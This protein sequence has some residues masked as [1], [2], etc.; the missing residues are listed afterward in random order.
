M[1]IFSLRERELY[2]KKDCKIRQRNLSLTALLY[3]YIAIFLFLFGWVKLVIAVPAGIALGYGL[4]HFARDIHSDNSTLQ[5]TPTMLF[6]TLAASLVI[7]VL[8]GAGGFLGQHDDWIKHNYLLHDLVTR[9]WPVYYEADGSP[10]MLTYYLGQ[11]LLPA[12]CG[13]LVHSFRMA[14][15]AQ[16]VYYAVGLFLIY[17]LLFPMV[18]ANTSRK[19]MSVLFIVPAFACC[20]LI[21]EALVFLLYAPVTSFPTNSCHLY[22]GPFSLPIRS[23]YGALS[24]IAV[25]TLPAWL[26][27]LLFAKSPKEISHYGLIV[28]PLLLSSTFAFIGLAAL[29]AG[30]L[31][32]TAWRERR[33]SLVK[34]VFSPLNLIA[35]VCAF[36]PFLYLSGNLFSEKPAEIGFA[37]TGIFG[38]PIVYVCFIVQFLIYSILVFPV[39]RK[40]PLFYL[41][42]LLLMILPVIKMGLYNDWLMNVSIPGVFLLMVFVLQALFRYA[43]QAARR[44]PAILLSGFLLVGAFWPAY[45]V[46][47]VIKVP[48][49]LHGAAA[50]YPIESLEIWAKR[51]G[52]VSPDMAYN[53]YTYDCETS[54]FAR[55]LSK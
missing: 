1:R 12:L 53:Y 41:V 49:T 3:L 32:V 54:L 48:P 5:I 11:Y 14:E 44:L 55:Y 16:L 26:A 43:G 2:E 46:L 7:M 29:M 52:S 9:S 13:K 28:M 38:A 35:V 4:F 33:L 21:S 31:F 25:Q 17:L 42:N 51:D 47:Q 15:L 36:V 19:Q 10:A 34:E 8:C 6:L 30:M 39:Q 22:A 50:R 37:F 27:A 23:N 40:N 24:A 18:G 45:E 20:L